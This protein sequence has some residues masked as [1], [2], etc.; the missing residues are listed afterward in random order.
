MAFVPVRRLEQHVIGGIRIEQRMEIHEIDRLILRVG[1]ADV[2]RD[3]NLESLSTY[4]EQ[5]AALSTAFGGP[6]PRKRGTLHLKIC[7]RWGA[8]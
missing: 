8:V 7:D 5:V 1:A 2:L 4:I 3:E 6:L